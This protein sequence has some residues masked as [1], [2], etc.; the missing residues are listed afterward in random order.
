MAHY[1]TAR[2][3]QRLFLGT[4]EI[5]GVQNTDIQ[6]QNGDTVVKYLGMTGIPTEP[7]EEQIGTAQISTLLVDS[8]YF[9]QYTGNSGIN[10]YLLR[11]RNDILYNTSFSSGY[12]SNYSNRCSIGQIPQ[13]NANFT[14]LGNVGSFTNAESSV[15]SGQFVTIAANSYNPGL[16]IAG[17]GSMSL[18]LDD[19]STNR[20]LSYDLGLSINRKAVYCLGQ[21]TPTHVEI[22]Y[23]IEVNATFRFEIDNYTLTA[24]RDYPCSKK[25]EDL[26][27]TLKSY[28]TDETIQS[29][30]FNDLTL[31]SEGYSANSDSFV[32]VMAQYRGFLNR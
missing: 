27:L 32:T 5:L 21:R 4:Q 24:M 12:L 20:V 16:R 28:N 13:I 10:G 31:I 14:V 8:D 23:P 19:F 11:A 1:R 18:S 30:N 3:S 22:I 17:Y 2:E 9:L 26:T 7:N 25:V 29:Y 15:V 6:Y